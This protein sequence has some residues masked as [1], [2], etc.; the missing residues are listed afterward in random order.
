[1]NQF[2]LVWNKELLSNRLFIG[3]YLKNEYNRLRCR[4]IRVEVKLTFVEAV[5]KGYSAV[6]VGD[7]FVVKQKI[8]DRGLALK[9][10]DDD[11]GQLGLFTMW[12]GVYFL[13]YD[14]KKTFC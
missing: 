12:T 6:R 4:T 10:T 13:D 7:K 9:V 14:G 3:F 1:M 2:H 11:R 8:G 5:V